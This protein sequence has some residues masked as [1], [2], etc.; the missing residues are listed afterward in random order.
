MSLFS[1][2]SEILQRH[3]IQLQDRCILF[4]GAIED[5]FVAQIHAK[6]VKVS[7]NQYH[8][9]RILQTQ[10]TDNV[11]F[12]LLPPAEMLTNIDTV[13]H[14]WHKNKQE[15]YFILSYLLSVLTTMTDLFIVGENRAGVRSVVEML[16][17]LGNISKIDTARRCS[18]Y[19]F[20]LEKNGD[21]DLEK[22]WSSY[23]YEGLTIKTLPGVFSAKHLDRGSE[24]LISAMKQ[25][26]Q[27]ITGNILD[28]GCGSGVL[29][30]ILATLNSAVCLTLADVSAAA[31]LSSKETLSVNRLTGHIV[32]SDVFSDLTDKYDLILSNPPFH[33]GRNID[34]SMIETLISQAKMRLT[35]KGRFCLVANAFL[36]Y[37]QRLDHFFGQHTLLAKTSRFKIYCVQNS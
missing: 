6:S 26:P 5:D 3:Q 1:P 37:P 2:A 33:E 12:D 28:I 18:L 21:F 9:C 34:L 24:L 10:L 25:N 22:W 20:K 4:T 19:Y 13:V 27:L 11:S 29:A 35:P 8:R 36:P 7:C 14:Y 17:P 30:A 31:L 32:A 23:Q 15:N 16:S